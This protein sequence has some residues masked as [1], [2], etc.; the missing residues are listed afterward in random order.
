MTTVEP[1]TRNTCTPTPDHGIALSVVVPVLN[2][3]H[4]I[5]P[6]LA[7]LVPVLDGLALAWEVVFVDDGSSDG[8]LAAL[9]RA[10]QRDPRLKTLSLSRNFGK[11]IAVAAGLQRARGAATIVM[12]ADLQHPPELIPEFVAKWREGYDDVYGQRI[13][14]AADS[15]ARRMVSL[16]YYRLFRILSGTRLPENAGDFR[17]LSRRAVDA[18][19]RMGE[20]ARFNKGLFAWIG[21]RSTGLPFDVP[22]RPDGGASRWRF[23]RLV[24]F[25]LDGI[26]SFTT[27]PLRIW[28]VI[29]LVISLLAFLY[30]VGFILKTLIFGTDLKGFPTLVVSIMFFSGIQLISLGV[31]GEYLG[32]IYE[33]VKARPLFLVG[34]EIGFDAAPAAEPLAGTPRRHGSRDGSRDGQ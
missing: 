17:L 34:E 20:R 30:I 7:R 32:R 28:S 26:F 23:R 4:G 14:R 18:L 11:E 16:V 24:R 22:D 1:E 9:R 25:A 12:D 15:A 29:G 2:E 3:E 19:N 27:I 8:T 5:G 21:F 33:E 10:H 6:L 13:D 31:I